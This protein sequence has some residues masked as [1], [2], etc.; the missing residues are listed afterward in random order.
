MIDQLAEQETKPILD[1]IRKILDGQ[2]SVKLYLEFLRKNNKT[3]MLILKHTKVG[4][5]L[6]HARIQEQC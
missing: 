1:T 6:L 4:Q 2:E 3:D 5:I